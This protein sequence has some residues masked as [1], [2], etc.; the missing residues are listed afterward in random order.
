MTQ[1]GQERPRHMPIAIAPLIACME[2]AA[3]L[4]LT[5]YALMLDG[6]R[7]TIMRGSAAPVIAEPSEP[8][9]TLLAEAATPSPDASLDAPMTG[10]CYLAADAAS[11]PFVAVGD[12][13][14]KGQTLCLIEAMKVMTSVPAPQDGT[15]TEVC[16]TDG[17]PVEAGQPLMR[18][19][20]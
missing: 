1:T 9:R 12:K 5:E 14:A 10:V 19:S 18:I 8:A 17:A 2:Q 7:V 4:G 15:V 6:R 3:R 20:T 16:V 11:R 13:V